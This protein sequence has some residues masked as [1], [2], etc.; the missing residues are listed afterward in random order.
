MKICAECGAHNS[1]ERMF[2]IDCDEKLDGKLSDADEEKMRETV[3][4]NIEKLYNKRDPLYVSLF[5]KIMGIASLAGAAVT[6]VL[7]IVDT[8]T[9]LNFEQLWV[10]A[11]FLVMASIEALVPRVTWSLEQLRLSFSISNAEEAEPSDFYLFFR[12]AGIVVSA[13][14]GMA[15]LVINFL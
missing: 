12:K 9:R 13:A 2:C 5:D 8:V 14:V 3:N 10:G 1:D 11:L 6:L 7:M 15:I 4:E